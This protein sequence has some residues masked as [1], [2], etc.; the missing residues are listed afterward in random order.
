M[1]IFFIYSKRS[2]IFMSGR[3]R[4]GSLIASLVFHAEMLL[5]NY[6]L[7]LPHLTTLGVLKKRSSEMHG[8]ISHEAVRKGAIY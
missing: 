5:L 4:A 8:Y 7:T 3:D 1:Q 6:T 2:I